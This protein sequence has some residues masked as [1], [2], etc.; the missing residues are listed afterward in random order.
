MSKDNQFRLP[1]DVHFT[2]STIPFS[3]QVDWGHRFLDVANSVWLHTKGEVNGKPLLVAILDTGI[4]DEHPDLRDAIED[5]VDCTN[6]RYGPRDVVGH[7]TMC[8]SI[9]GA[10]ADGNGIIGVLPKCKI[11]SIKVL[12]DNGS[13]SDDSI[14]KGLKLALERKAVILNNSYGGRSMSPRVAELF[15]HIAQTK[16]RFA[17]CASGNDSGAVNAPARYRSTLAIGALDE[18]GRITK[19]T[20]RGPELDALAPGKG[21]MGCAPNGGYQVADGTSFGCPYAGAIGGAAWCKHQASGGSTDLETTEQMR[22][23]LRRGGNDGEWK[24]VDPRKMMEANGGKLPVAGTEIN[25]GIGKLRI[26][27]RAGDW[28]SVGSA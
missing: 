11:L 21:I 7:G 16:H 13:G 18:Q 4:D 27:A 28:F 2:P 14:Y 5:A 12:G 26:P 17:F 24:I 22:E 25:L 1:P 20:S 23:H 10:R 6:S 8:A 19:F 15:D 9:Y 3:E